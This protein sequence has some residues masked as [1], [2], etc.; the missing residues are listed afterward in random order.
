MLKIGQQDGIRL[1]AGN[2][3]H[4][5]RQLSASMM[6]TTLTAASICS[7]QRFLRSIAI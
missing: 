1:P 3:Q 5:A 6:T 2:Y 7:E 4:M